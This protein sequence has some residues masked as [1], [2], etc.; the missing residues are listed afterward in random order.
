MEQ[1]ICEC[2]LWP[3]AG[4]PAQ[5]PEFKCP[6]GWTDCCCRCLLYTQPD[7]KAQKSQLKE[8]IKGMRGNTPVNHYPKYH[9][10]LNFI[11]QFWG[12]AKMHYHTAPQAKTAR[13]MESTVKDSLDSVPIHQIR[14][15]ANQAARFVSAYRDGLSGSQA[16]WAN[17]KYHGHRTLPPESILEAKDA[18]SA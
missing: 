3:D 2:G 8:L 15:F 7:F 9:C 17:K 14:R 10:E 13:A 5:C 1:L 6:P 11:E 4:L 16:A 12:A 18:I